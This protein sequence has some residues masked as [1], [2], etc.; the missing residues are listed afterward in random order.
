[1]NM[2]DTQSLFESLVIMAFMLGYVVVLWVCYEEPKLRKMHR[3]SVGRAL[4]TQ[5]LPWSFRLFAGLTLIPA[6]V[7]VF[8]QPQWW[9]GPI[10]SWLLGMAAAMYGFKR[11]AP[12]SFHRT[13]NAMGIGCLASGMATLMAW[14]DV[15]WT[16]PFGILLWPLS[17]VGIAALL[18]AAALPFEP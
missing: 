7:V 2:Q 10:A 18:Y 3:K 13:I 6:G 15:Y 17:V 1:M 12:F 11:H 4:A 8:M 14:G 9:F 16:I 5:W